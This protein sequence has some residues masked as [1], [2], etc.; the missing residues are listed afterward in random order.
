MSGIYSQKL[1]RHGKQS[2]TDE[3]KTASKRAIQKTAKT[4]GDLIVDKIAHRITKVSKNSQQNYSE[5]VTIDM[6]KK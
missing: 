2:A 6:T 1:L 5:T 4:T 3:I